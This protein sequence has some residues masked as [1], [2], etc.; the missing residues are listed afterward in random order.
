MLEKA[1][2]L[3]S[4][5]NI[6]GMPTETVYGLAASIYS[7]KALKKIFTV[8]ERP[9]FDPLIVH[10]GS[11]NE[12]IPLVKAWPLSVQALA[13]K[14]WPGPLTLVL[15]KSSLVSDLITSGLPTVA[16]RMP[17]HPIA[18]LLISKFGSPLAA[19]SANKFGKTSPTT[20]AHVDLEF[21]ND[22]ILVL[23]GG[24]C[25]VGI[26]STVLSLKQDEN[27]RVHIS[28]LRPGQILL[29]EIIKT[30]ENLDFKVTVV[31]NREKNLA[32]GQ[33]K[34]HYMPIKPLVF[35]SSNIEFNK[36]KKSILEKISALPD[37]ED[38]VKIIKPQ[39][40]ETY[41][42]LEL[43][44]EPT[45]AARELYAKLREVCSGDED[46]ILFQKESFHQGEAWE[47][48]FDRM[49]KAATVII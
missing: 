40:I 9:F 42:K 30:L 4:Q 15:E 3:L 21:L 29:N 27:N 33:M 12:A 19:P 13:E 14:F 49:M 8:K 18:L 2:E 24:A 11:V 17:S 35:S 43:S 41:K 6:V 31:L 36:I 44:N 26:E 28:I 20:K 23:E 16:I 10:V 45:I 25:T 39:K 5:D 46:I 38:E 37:F 1:L 22:N 7:E 32:P 48:I 47:G 34:H